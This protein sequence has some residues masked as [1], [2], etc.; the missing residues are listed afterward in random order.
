VYVLSDAV[1]K[2]G[3]GR[4]DPSAAADETPVPPCIKPRAEPA[5]CQI[6][7]EIEDRADKASVL[8]VSRRPQ[9]QH[10]TARPAFGEF[11]LPAAH[12]NSSHLSPELYIACST[13]FLLIASCDPGGFWM[14]QRSRVLFCRSC[15]SSCGWRSRDPSPQRRPAKRSWRSYGACWACASGSCRWSEGTVRATKRCSWR[16]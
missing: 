6:A 1:T 8:K 5:G 7:V 16:A 10:P 15:Q 4:S 9:H 11:C 14:H 13:V 2:Y 12:D 3:T